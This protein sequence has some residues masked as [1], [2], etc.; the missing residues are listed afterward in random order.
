VKD[1]LR[2]DIL[3][4]RRNGW[5]GTTGITSSAAAAT[6][7]RE[8]G[9]IV[10]PDGSGKVGYAAAGDIDLNGAVSVFDLVGINGSGTYGAGIP[11]DWSTG[12]F[13]FDGKT[14]V[15]DLVAINTAGVY[16]AGNYLPPSSGGP[17]PS[18][19]SA[20]PEPGS[21]G[22]GGLAVAGAIALL[23]RRLSANRRAL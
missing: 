6:S 22:L 18:A 7:G 4:G 23:R 15:F 8:V 2:A 1:D 20:V 21:L 14:N 16:G 10:N 19:I 3:A 17:G 13:N 9:Y 11:S 5:T 12:D